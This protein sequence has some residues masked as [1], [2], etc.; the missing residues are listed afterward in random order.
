M[1]N[2]AVNDWH[3]GFHSDIQ[4]ALAALETQLETIT[5]TKTIRLIDVKAVG[6]KWI[7]VLVYDA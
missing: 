2:Y 6:S 5:N 1:T 4:D 3:S 7:A